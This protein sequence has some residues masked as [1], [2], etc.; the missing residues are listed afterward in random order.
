MRHFIISLL[1][2]FSLVS[3]SQEVEFSKVILKGLETEVVVTSPSAFGSQEIQINGS[4]YQFDSLADEQ[5]IKIVAGSEP[6]KVTIGTKT[7]RSSCTPIP[8]GWSILPPLM[9]I[10]LALAFREVLSALF[11]GIF[12]GCIIV[13]IYQD[14]LGGVFSGFLRTLDEYIIQALMDSGHLSVVLFSMIIGAVVHIISKNGGMNSIVAWLSKKAQTAQSG[15]MATY[16]MGVMIFFDDYANTLVVGNTMRPIT[17]KLKISRE[18]LAYIVDS[19]AA[20]V[21]A[22]AFVTTWIGAELG[23]IMEAV[24]KSGDAGFLE[25]QSA[26]GLFFQSIPYSFYPLLTLLFIF[27]LIKS[28]KD[29]G[30]MLK[31]EREARKAVLASDV[32][33][34]KLVTSHPINAILPIVIIVFGTLLGL[35]FTGFESTASAILAESPNAKLHG[36]GDV[37]REMTQL[38]TAPSSFGTKLGT[39]IG[40]ADS[41]QALLWASLG[42]LAASIVL[43]VGFTKLKF[44]ETMD[45]AMEGFKTM[46]PAIL[47][48]VLS[49]S[50]ASVTETLHTADF[51]TSVVGDSIHPG[52]F[53]AITFILAA[54]VAFSTGSSWG[55]M[56]I[57]Y[58]LVLPALTSVCLQFGLDDGYALSLFLNATSCI[59]AGSV[60]GDHC[61]PISDTTILSSLASSCDHISHVKTQMPYALSVGGVALLL[62]TIP[63]GWGVSPIWLMLIGGA[64]VFFIIKFVGKKVETEE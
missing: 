45:A 59:L 9:A 36:W 60:L 23:Y 13:G 38:P 4:T 37:W 51:L 35:L 8:L 56:A 43:S 46:L 28:K 55:T 12:S 22:I 29:F 63:A 20:P 18:K 42:S 26:Y 27:L 1:L 50:L 57:L 15:Q 2:L 21:A 39:V 34:E 54:L 61:S 11:A 7:F 6:V 64:A 31:V 25:G 58:P 32:K 3:Q 48:L 5:T 62:G 44:S 40:N 17:D 47:I 30:P 49:W 10:V 16:I 33:E 53:P 19:T 41:Y 14:G 24:E 52:W